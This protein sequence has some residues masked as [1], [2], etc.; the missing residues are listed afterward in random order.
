MFSIN[1]NAILFKEKLYIFRCFTKNMTNRF[2]SFK[3]FE[4]GFYCTWVRIMGYRF[5]IALD[6]NFYLV[7][8]FCVWPSHFFISMKFLRGFN[9]FR[10]VDH[11]V[12]L[13]RLLLLRQQVFC[14]SNA[15]FNR[16]SIRRSIMYALY[17][18]CFYCYSYRF[19]QNLNKLDAGDFYVM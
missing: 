4:L 5:E 9:F 6:F 14:V 19:K 11:F 17:C 12:F 15:F 3:I 10:T 8:N 16:V 7:T 13:L 2:P 1:S 18:Y